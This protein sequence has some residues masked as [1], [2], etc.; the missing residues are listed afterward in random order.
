VSRKIFGSKGSAE[1]ANIGEN[2]IS[3]SAAKNTKI[4]YPLRDI[5]VCSLKG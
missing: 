3:S 1:R 2:P 4:N 5:F